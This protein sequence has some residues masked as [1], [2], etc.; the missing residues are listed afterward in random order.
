MNTES[1]RIVD[2]DTAPSICESMPWSSLPSSCAHSRI[3]DSSTSPWAFARSESTASLKCR[4]A[5]RLRR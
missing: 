3:K 2:P 1:C 4:P 5:R